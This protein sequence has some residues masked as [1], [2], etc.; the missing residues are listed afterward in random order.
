MIS[1][2]WNNALQPLWIAGKLLSS[3]IEHKIIIDLLNEIESTTGWQMRLRIRDLK[4][5]WSG[6][7][8]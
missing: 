1:G 7:M 5:Y 4:K 2:C 6:N 3:D 8:T